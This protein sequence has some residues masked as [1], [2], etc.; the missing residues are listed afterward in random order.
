MSRPREPRWARKLIEWLLSEDEVEFVLGDLAED[1]Q[2]MA[3][4]EGTAAARAWYGRQTI[5]TLAARLVQPPAPLEAWTREARISARR[6]RREPSYAAT[7]VGT[8]ALGIGG[9]AAVGGLASSVLSPLPYPD[10]GALVSV[11]ETREGER[12]GVAPA[13]YLDWRRDA[14]SF[15]GLAAHL[16]RSV[17]V[18]VDGAASREQVAVV[19]GNFFDVLG[20]APAVGR[21]FDPALDVAFEERLVVLSAEAAERSFGTSAD[22]VGRTVL[23]DDRAHQVVGV[24]PAGFAFPVEELYGWVRSPSEAPDIRGFEG[25]LTEMRDAWYFRV[26][27][28]LEEGRSIEDAR[29]EM[30]ALAERLAATYPETNEGSSVRIVP[31]LEETVAGFGSTLVALALA[32]VLLLGGAVLNLVHL[33][34][35]RGETRRADIGVRAALG[36]SGADLR[37]GALVEGTLVGLLGGTVGLGLAHWALAVSIARLG[38]AVPRAAEVGVT[39]TLA[40]A[41]LGLGAAIGAAV[42]LAALP[43]RR[44]RR[45]AFD[46][47]RPAGVGVGGRHLVAAQVA[48]SIA[49]LTGAVLLSASLSKLGAVDLGFRTDG[50]TTMRIAMPDALDREPAERLARYRSVAEAVRRVPGVEAV[51][52]GSDPPVDMGAQAGVFI[53]G[54]T[55]PSDP[56][57]AGWQPVDA[58]YFATME[59]RLARGRGFGPADGRDDADVA[60]VNEAF[61]RGVLGGAEPLGLQVT[62]GLDGHDRPLT[63]VGVVQDTRTLGPAAPAGPVLYRPLDQ[64]TRFR[65]TSILLAVRW[66]DEVRP[67]PAQ[68]RRAIRSAAPALPVYAEANGDDLVRPFR[69]SRTLL[70]TV[71]AAFSICALAI[72]MV[73]VYGVGMHAVRRQRRAIGVRLALGATRM[74]ITRE[75]VGLGM[76]GALLGVP[77]GVLLA[78]LVGRSMSSLLY[79][80]GASDPLALASV[81]AV[82]LGLTAMALF[83]PARAAAATDPARTTKDG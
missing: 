14:R 81:T 10:S 47:L 6:L 29:A 24:A 67:A 60:I 40:V 71:M 21:G 49:V 66:A 51:A 9:V 37:R 32:V 65:G 22:P 26:V 83:L 15:A 4:R 8:L 53:V 72:G 50:L 5:A 69:R 75:V 80:V 30:A 56:P 64:A 61:V 35:A 63:I 68:V 44:S 31:L 33:G 45:S 79:E 55:R 74:R 82:V 25:N 11:W 20:V 17:A 1:F 52:L 16:T 2:E 13:N 58:A 59:M 19:S 38:G 78:L 27:G 28:R 42:A 36:A 62:M 18:T 57:N 70:L 7:A 46:L 77:P 23:V 3:R 73:G 54:G 43:L 41:G 48:I 39:A 34:L 76:G 12:R